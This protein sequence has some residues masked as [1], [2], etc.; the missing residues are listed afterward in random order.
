[1]KKL[2]V[3]L[4]LLVC[5][6]SFANTLDPS[7]IYTVK[8]TVVMSSC[9]DII[10]GTSTNEQW[11]VNPANA[12]YRIQ[13]TGNLNPN[14]A[15]SDVAFHDDNLFGRYTAKDMFGGDAGVSE[16][17]V[18]FDKKSKAKYNIV[19]FRVIAK[20]PPHTCTSVIGLQLKKSN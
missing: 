2:G 16:I 3:L 18:V 13:V 19:G 10:E 12:G 15:Y 5:G 7:G 4:G 17:Q 9:K 11:V 20:F 14:L 8:T 6:Q 1:M